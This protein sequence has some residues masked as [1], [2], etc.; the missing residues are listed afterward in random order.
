VLALSNCKNEMDLASTVNYS[1]NQCHAVN[2]LATSKVSGLTVEE[3]NELDEIFVQLAKIGGY[4]PCQEK[5]VVDRKSV[6]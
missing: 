6:V 1:Q 2:T 5:S 3:A 4:A